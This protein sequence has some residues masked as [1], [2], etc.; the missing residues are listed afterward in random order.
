[1]EEFSVLVIIV[2]ILASDTRSLARSTL[3]ADELGSPATDQVVAP[4]MYR[5]YHLVEKD[6]TRGTRKKSTV[7]SL[8][9]VKLDTYKLYSIAHLC[10]R[11]MPATTN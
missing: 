11:W 7:E 3:C 4:P 5:V 9:M 6:T 8:C 2:M 10:F 1:V